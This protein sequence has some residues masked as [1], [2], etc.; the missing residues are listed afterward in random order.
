MWKWGVVKGVRQSA[1]AIQKWRAMA[2]SGRTFSREAFQ[3]RD[4]RIGDLI[5]KFLVVA[6]GFPVVHQPPRTFLHVNTLFDHT[7]SESDVLC[8]RLLNPLLC[9]VVQVEE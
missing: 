5:I 4:F 2:Y 6:Q 9:H 8:V 3:T 7:D 1:L